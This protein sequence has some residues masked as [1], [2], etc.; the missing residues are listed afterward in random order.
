MQSYPPFLVI[1]IVIMM[2]LV[3]GLYQSMNT[4]SSLFSRNEH[5]CVVWFGEYK[6]HKYKSPGQTMGEGKCLVES[7]WMQVLQ[8]EVRLNPDQ[9]DTIDDWLFINYHDRINVLVEDPSPNSNERH[10]LVFEQSKYALEGRTSLA[11]IGGIIEPGEDPISAAK[12]EVYEEMNEMVCEKYAFL[13]RYRTD[14]NRGMGWVNG[15]LASNCQR[16]GG[17]EGGGFVAPSKEDPHNQIG[18]MDTERQDLKSISLS[19]L[20]RQTMKGSFL[21][22]QWSN[23]VSL[24]LLRMDE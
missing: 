17:D 2:T 6:G 7:K 19:E 12:R 15:F 13:G 21:E 9:K 10:F 3:F 20:R 23:T 18:A 11:I 4:S 22:V 16:G 5:N 1:L 14:V 8:H 24:A